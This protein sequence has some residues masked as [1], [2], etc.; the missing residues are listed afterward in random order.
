MANGNIK[1]WGV[2]I[3]N[4]SSANDLKRNLES[5]FWDINTAKQEI[6]KQFNQ[7]S[8][9]SKKVELNALKNRI[10]NELIWDNSW[11]DNTIWSQDTSSNQNSVSTSS[12]NNTTTNTS[13]TRDTSWRWGIWNPNFWNNDSWDNSTITWQN[14]ASKTLSNAIDT[15]SNSSPNEIKTKVNNL[16]GSQ[17][18]INSRLDKAID[19]ASWGAKWQLQTLKDEINKK[20]EVSGWDSWNGWNSW[21]EWGEDEW[22]IDDIITEVWDQDLSSWD[23]DLP[24]VN[25]N[26]EDIK[27]TVDNIKSILDNTLKQQKENLEQIEWV[28]EQTK[29]TLNNV[30]EKRVNNA[31]STFE[32]VKNDLSKLR[33]QVLETFDQNIEQQAQARASGLANRWL[34]TSE[35]SWRAAQRTISQFKNQAELKKWEL[36]QQITENLIQARKEKNQLIDKIEQQRS[37][38]AVTKNKLTRQVQQA[39]N[40]VLQNFQT[41]KTSLD[42]F[43]IQNVLQTRNP[44]VS[45]EKSERAAEIKDEVQ[46]SIDEKQLERANESVEDR[47]RFLA[48]SIQE[49]NPQILWVVGDDIKNLANSSWFMDEDPQQQLL[50]LVEDWF[51]KLVAQQSSGGGSDNWGISAVEAIRAIWSNNSSSNDGSSNN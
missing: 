13:W 6:D 37:A 3:I 29:Q 51:R 21:S 49:L 17:S 11:K 28:T 42:E 15:I 34:L 12:A 39:Y 1:R 46:N 36:E 43:E 9:W 35:Q 48:N 2:S 14:S 16:W 4:K 20:F 10:D 31:K 18:E 22:G 5:K 25:K 47:V 8:W 38:D 44:Q 33:N 41:A 30:I 19:N 23:T 24:T 26:E 27:T 50:W 7:T 32:N 40:N 45:L